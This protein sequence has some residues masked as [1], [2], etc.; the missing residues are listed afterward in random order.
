MNPKKLKFHFTMLAWHSRTMAEATC[1]LTRFYRCKASL[2]MALD[3][4]MILE[5]VETQRLGDEVYPGQ[6]LTTKFLGL[7]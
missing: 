3:T 5:H 7:N 2:S 4:S 1:E 6:R